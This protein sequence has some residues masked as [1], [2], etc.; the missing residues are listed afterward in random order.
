MSLVG[1]GCPVLY[2]ASLAVV[3]VPADVVVKV[4]VVSLPATDVVGIVQ[5]SPGSVPQDHLQKTQMLLRNP[6]LGIAS[7]TEQ[8]WLQKGLHGQKGCAFAAKVTS[9]GGVVGVMS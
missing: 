8:L 1:L 7:R 9:I 2:G 3:I 5:A 6:S 4:V